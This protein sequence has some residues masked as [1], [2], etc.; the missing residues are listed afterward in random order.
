MFESEHAVCV[1]ANVEFL[2]I[3]GALAESDVKY[4]QFELAVNA[5]ERAALAGAVELRD[6]DSRKPSRLSR[7]PNSAA[8]RGRFWRAPCGF[9][10]ALPS[11]FPW[12]AG[13]PPCRAQA[14]SPLPPLPPPSSP[15][16]WRRR[17]RRARSQQA[18]LRDAAPIRG[19]ARSRRLGKCR[20]PRA[21][22]RRRTREFSRASRRS[23]SCPRR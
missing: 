18:S 20:M 16:R 14:T 21:P 4:R 19:F 13:A 17:R 10:R 22:P 9:L 11:S 7:A 1:G 8:R 15:T 23:S 2:K 12:C 3:P 5:G 6:D